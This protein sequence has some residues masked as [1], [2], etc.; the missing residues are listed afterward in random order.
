MTQFT[1]QAPS[2]QHDN[3]GTPT[4]PNQTVHQFKF[5]GN[6]GEYFKIWIVNLFLTIIT[7]GIY[8][9][10]AKV[11][12]LR[13]FYG[14]TQLDNRSFDFTANPK[15]I[16]IGRLI[17]I[18]L[19][20]LIMIG[21]ELSWEIA[22]ATPILLFIALPWLFR[23][24]LKFHARHSQ[25]NNVK[26][27][28]KGSL[29]QTYGLF[30]L[31]SLI[32]I[33]SFGLLLPVVL[34]LIRGYQFNNLYF[35]N[36]KFDFKATITDFYKA[37]VLPILLMILTI[38]GVIFFNFGIADVIDASADALM[39]GSIVFLYLLSLLVMPLMTAYIYQATYD[40][41]TIGNNT[42]KLVNF[43]P[44]KLALIIVSNYFAIIVS[45]GLLSAWAAI[46]A[47]RYKMQTLSLVAVDD[48]NNLTTP[49]G[50]E[51]SAIGEE[52]SDVFD[53]DISW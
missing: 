43:S 22:I 9:P 28:F 36:L 5:T 41:M 6:A 4:P 19:Y 46:R 18:A 25:Y 35:G 39:V 37:A 12:R 48:L 51:I 20:A 16:L 15:K 50:E 32:S 1:P 21:G 14:N 24:T 10:W 42:L 44:L 52:I 33:V 38:I 8:S 3:I 23:S 7:L 45:L 53:F 47:H 26:F 30:L 31:T 29:G 27:A 49:Q 17:A 34:W 2:T 13:Y 11:R 40:G